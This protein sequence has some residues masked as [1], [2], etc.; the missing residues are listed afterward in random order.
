MKQ[1]GYHLAR[2]LQGCKG[3]LCEH[4][5]G[6]QSCLDRQSNASGRSTAAKGLPHKML[7]ST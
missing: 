3:I 4:R 7:Y 1:N 2:F 6:S 5:E